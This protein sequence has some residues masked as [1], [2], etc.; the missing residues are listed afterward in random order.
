MKKTV[1]PDILLV[2]TGPI[3]IEYAKI[4]LKLKKKFVAVGRSKSSCQNFLAQTGITAHP[5]GIQQWLY[6]QSKLGEDLPAKAIIAASENELGIVT[7][8]C[9]K[10]GVRNI[11][12]EKPGGLNVNE[13]K[14]VAKESMKKNAKVFIGYNRRQYAS[15]K[16][17]KK[18]LKQDGGVT[19]FNFEFTE[20]GHVIKKIK[21]APGVKEQWF[22]HNS[23]HVIDLA[24]FLGGIPKKII[25]FSKGSL[26]W[27]PAGAIFT[28]AGETASGALFSY[29]ANWA[30]PGRWGV[31]I[32]TKKHRYIFRPLEKL[33]V[34]QLGSVEISEIPLSNNYDSSFKPGFFEQTRAFILGQYK[35]LCTIEEQKKHCVVYTKILRN[36]SKG[37]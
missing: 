16:M 5:G 33:Q 2:G 29:Q 11:L 24:F 15:V 26:P 8:L 20:W 25:T 4:L 18:L 21:K 37:L 10:S 9:L 36:S 3:G 23:T 31:E 7:L 17:C 14:Q 27:H 13:I 12:V 34:Q 19:S 1:R 35:T 32:L 30:A 6:M 22:L 28:G